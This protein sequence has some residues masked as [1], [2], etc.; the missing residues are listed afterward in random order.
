MKNKFIKEGY[1]NLDIN[2]LLSNSK[3]NRNRSN[4]YTVLDKLLGL[5]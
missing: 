2:K 3:P 1:K 4:L 5:K